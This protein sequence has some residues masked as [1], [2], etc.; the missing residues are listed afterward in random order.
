MKCP[1]TRPNAASGTI[2]VV[3]LPSVPMII[4]AVFMLPVVHVPI[5]LG[6]SG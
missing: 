6:I 5:L 1:G 2:G 4:Y 3:N